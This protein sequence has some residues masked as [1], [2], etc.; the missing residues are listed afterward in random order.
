[1]PVRRNLA[2]RMVGLL[3]ASNSTGPQAGIGN[4]L[5]TGQNAIWR[6]AIWEI[7]SAWIEPTVWS[8]A[9]ALWSRI[10]WGRESA[11]ATANQQPEAVVQAVRPAVEFVAV[12]PLPQMRVERGRGRADGRR[13]SG[14]PQAQ[15]VPSQLPPLPR[16]GAGLE[17]DFSNPQH[18]DRLPSEL[19]TGLPNQG[20]V[21]Y[22]E[23]QSV[24]R[25]LRQLAADCALRVN[26]SASLKLGDKVEVGVVALFP[27][28]AELIRRLLVQV[29]A[30]AAL[31][32]RVDTPAGF[33]Q[34]ECAIVV[35]S[36]TRSHGNR[37]VCYG[38]GPQALAL[39]L[40]RVRQR[41]VICGDPGTLSR[42]R[43]WEGQVDP[44]DHSASACERA[45][46]GRLTDYLQ[47]QGAE[48]QAFRLGEGGGS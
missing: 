35:L 40:T 37:A 22:L 12:P 28:Q 44:L 5:P 25:V 24:I 21:N 39:A 43:Q 20:F 27:A 42:R 38:E 19:R 41:L 10:S 16:M 15:P 30:L 7:R 13:I 17:L 14:G 1:M 48:P 2:S 3:A 29:P 46:V 32:I 26:G 47:G 31:E 45:I 34:Q 11:I 4:A 6:S 9:S 8:Q 36:L 33:S 23:A 18:R